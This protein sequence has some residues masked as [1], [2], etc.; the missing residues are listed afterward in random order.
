MRPRGFYGRVRR[1]LAER[2]QIAMLKYT[3]LVIVSGMEE[4]N[5]N[6]VIAL[7]KS[8]SARAHHTVQGMRYD[9]EMSRQ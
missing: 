7:L 3:P 5:L 6:K 8:G 9:R 2:Y 1:I 4:R